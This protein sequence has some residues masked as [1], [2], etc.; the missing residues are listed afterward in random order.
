MEL[1][2]LS[3]RLETVAQFVP[4]KARLLDVGSDHAY[5]PIALVQAGTIDFAIAGEV[6]TGPFQSAMNN[7]VDNHL[8]EQIQVRLANGLKAF[9]ESDAITCITIA[10]MGGRLIADILA[11]GKDKLALVET[12]VLQPNNREDEL[13]LWLVEHGFSIQEE[14]ILEENGK[15]YEVLFA[16]HGSQKLTP[17]ELRFGPKLMK[18]AT[19]VFQSK[20]QRES[21]KL[22][23]ALAQIPK[24]NLSDRSV[25]EER[26][27]MI[28]EVLHASQ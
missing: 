2:K 3:K 13:R 26:L 11:E 4:D 1:T 15:V 10:G 12:L 27:R 25:I 5:L 23:Q 7:V 14:A 20:W 17:Q 16:T 24:E 19:P 6:V 28:Q 21:N 22:G 9:E 18:E 8:E